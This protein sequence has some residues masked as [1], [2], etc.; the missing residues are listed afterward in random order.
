MIEEATVDCYDEEEQLLGLFTMIEDNL[1]IPFETEILG[2]RV[3]VTDVEQTAGG[4]I[5]AICSRDRFRQSVP[6]VDLPLPTPP[7]DG[8]EWIDAYRRWLR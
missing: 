1:T 6:L 5:V 8:S 3:T 2:V 4:Q 7:P